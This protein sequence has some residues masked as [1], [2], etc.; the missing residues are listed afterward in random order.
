MFLESVFTI[1]TNYAIIIITIADVIITT[2]CTSATV[3]ADKASTLDFICKRRSTSSITMA[4]TNMK[5][6]NSPCSNPLQIGDWPLKL[7][8]RASANIELVAVAA[9]IDRITGVRS[10]ACCCSSG[11]LEAYFRSPSKY[12][13]GSLRC[14][15]NWQTRKNQY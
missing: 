6:K 9:I 10:P 13:A 3:V 12:S 11:L 7:G 14:K 5:A 1:V 4:S 2:Q 15:D 8:L